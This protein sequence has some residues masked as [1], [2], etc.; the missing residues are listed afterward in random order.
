MKRSIFILFVT[1]AASVVSSSIVTAGSPA[2]EG[3]TYFVYVVGL[4]DDPY[5]PQVDCLA[6][7][8]THACTLDGGTCLEW[9]R[10]EEESGTPKESGFS[11]FTEIDE[12]GLLVT[13][14]GQGRV[15][16]RGS[17]SSIAAVAQAAALDQ[18]INFSLAGRQ[19]SRNRCLAMMEDFLN[20]E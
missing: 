3:R 17:R 14:K 19:T 4:D 8:A 12:D 5:L 1:L 10:V 18:R 9:Q 16:S 2:P 20:Q 7:D 6:F 11:L 13:M 15:D